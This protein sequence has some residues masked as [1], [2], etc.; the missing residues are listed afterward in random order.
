MISSKKPI[1]YNIIESPESNKHLSIIKLSYNYSQ[2]TKK[3][4]GVQ[5]LVNVFELIV[6]NLFL[7]LVYYYKHT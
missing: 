3:L 2:I 1:G 4:I 5:R 6:R 7:V